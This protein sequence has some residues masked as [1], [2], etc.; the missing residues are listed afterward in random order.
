MKKKTESVFQEHIPGNQRKLNC[1]D[2]CFQQYPIKYENY[3]ERD[4]RWEGKCDEMARAWI[5]LKK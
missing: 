3:E 4:Q 1:I 2:F 5:D